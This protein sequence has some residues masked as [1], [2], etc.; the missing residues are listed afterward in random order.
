LIDFLFI[1]FLKFVFFQNLTFLKKFPLK[2]AQFFFEK[3]GTW[4][5]LP[6]K[7]FAISRRN[8]ETKNFCKNQQN[9][10]LEGLWYKKKLKVF[11]SASKI[12]IIVSIG[13]RMEY[14]S[15]FKYMPI[16][17]HKTPY[18]YTHRKTTSNPH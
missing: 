2:T 15:I 5:F 17:E 6:M 9:R 3:V 1:I 8:Q 11:V 14:I 18:L 10:N 12:R 13:N 7:F 4:P 16:L